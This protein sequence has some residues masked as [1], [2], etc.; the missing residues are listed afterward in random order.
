MIGSVGHGGDINPHLFPPK[1]HHGNFV[2]IFVR[3]VMREPH[4]DLIKSKVGMNLIFPYW[5]HQHP[6]SPCSLKLRSS[7]EQ[8]GT[9]IHHVHL[10]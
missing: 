10:P 5:E 3:E 6:L 2:R 7:R 8:M 9:L 1:I 4:F